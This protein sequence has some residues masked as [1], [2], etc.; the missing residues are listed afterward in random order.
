MTMRMF[1]MG[2]PIL[3]YSRNDEWFELSNFYP[4]GFEEDG[5]YW[6]SIEHYFQAQKFAGPEMAEY[7]ERIR[8]CGSP[9]HA[10]DLGR[11]TKYAIRRDWDSVR[12]EIMLYALR[13]KFAHPKLRAVLLATENRELH[14]NSPFDAYWGVGR[15]GGGVSRLGQ[16]LMQV[17]EEIRENE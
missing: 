5:A 14:E 9:K 16:L 11:T 3:F 6:P 8:Q 12:D 13:R 4:Q 15:D 17:R 2:S 1:E 7:R 10:K